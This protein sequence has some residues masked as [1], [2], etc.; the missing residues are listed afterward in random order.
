MYDEDVIQTAHNK[1]EKKM[2]DRF[3]KEI[4]KNVLEENGFRVVRFS[5][6][7]GTDDI[8]VT[9]EFRNPNSESNCFSGPSVFCR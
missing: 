2:A 8:S 9:V 6:I 5:K 4:A 3:I 1:G 7:Y